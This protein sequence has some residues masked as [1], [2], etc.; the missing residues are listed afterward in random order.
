MKKDYKKNPVKVKPVVG[1]RGFLITDP[2]LITI[3]H[4]DDICTLIEDGDFLDTAIVLVGIDAEFFHKMMN[5]RKTYAHAKYAHDAIK[6]AQALQESNLR[7]KIMD[8]NQF[9]AKLLYEY[10]QAT[11]PKLQARVRQEVKYNNAL[12]LQTIHT[13]LGLEAYQRVLEALA[14]QD[15]Y[16][17]IA[18][19]DALLLHE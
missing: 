17:V 5:N 13:T 6:Q 15:P 2:N 8:P 1:S 14:Q 11:N 19:L 9:N 10:M 4:I 7:K 16:Q 3:Q 18:S 12:L